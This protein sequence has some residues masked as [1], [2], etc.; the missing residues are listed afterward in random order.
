MLAPTILGRTR[1]LE[2]L[3]PR[4]D[5]QERRQQPLVGLGLL[6]GIIGFAMTG[7]GIA[8]GE[9][10]EACTGRLWWREC[11]ESFNQWSL[12]TRAFLVVGGIGLVTGAVALGIE[13]FRT[14]TQ[15]KR[16]QPYATILTGVES[17]TIEQLA[18]ITRLRP[19]KVRAQI[20]AQIESGQIEGFYLDHGADMVVY[21]PA[22][23]HKTVVRCT[24]CGGPNEVIVGITRPC[25]F[26][27]QPLLLGPA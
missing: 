13:A 3:F 15:R 21:V 24:E 2:S 23:S 6:L 17:M 22:T 11:E 20:Q 14:G 27:G 19:S 16:V 18:A 26:C 4:P 7:L 25:S 9:S 5:K 8:G 1:M 12:G 10:V